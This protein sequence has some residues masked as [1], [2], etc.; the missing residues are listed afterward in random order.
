MNRPTAAEND[1]VRV[2]P[3]FH[4]ANPWREDRWSGE[5]K[6]RTCEILPRKWSF[7]PSTFPPG[8]SADPEGNCLHPER[9]RADPEG[10]RLHRERMRAYPE[11]KRSNPRGSRQDQAGISTDPAGTHPHPAGTNK[12]WPD[13]I[14]VILA[15]HRSTPIRWDRPSSQGCRSSSKV[16][17]A[18]HALLA[19]SKGSMRV[20]KASQW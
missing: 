4:V 3:G 10:N 15:R 7:A 18:C 12:E 20:T 9:M 6:Y 8:N 16:F 1:R 2:F 11:R 5:A 17:R 14:T 13:R 19:R